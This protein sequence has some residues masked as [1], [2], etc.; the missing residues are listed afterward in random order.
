MIK[1][2][3]NCHR[4]VFKQMR[5]KKLWCI[6]TLM[7]EDGKLILHRIDYEEWERNR[8]NGTVECYHI[9]DEENTVRLA[10]F[11]NAESSVKLIRAVISHIG[12]KEGPIGFC[13]DFR[14]LCECQNIQYHYNVWY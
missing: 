8:R 4:V 5:D 11:F 14:K 9:L 12:K 1:V 13:G 2:L 6:L 3:K 7:V 10:D